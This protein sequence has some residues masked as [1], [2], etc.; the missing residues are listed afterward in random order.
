MEECRKNILIKE[1]ILP[2]L[3]SDQGE[4]HEDIVNPSAHQN[5]FKN[6]NVETLE[7]Q[8]QSFFRSDFIS[9]F[10]N[11]NRHDF[12]SLSLKRVHFDEHI[13]DLAQFLKNVKTRITTIILDDCDIGDTSISQMIADCKKITT[14]KELRL[15]RMNLNVHTNEIL[16]N[17]QDHKMLKVLDLSFNNIDCMAE[18]S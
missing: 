4:R 10:I 3:Q 13:K 6:Y 18:I 9:K 15:T 12:H 2:H 16:R 8:D 7:L 14:L 11:M 1:F 17:L 5:H